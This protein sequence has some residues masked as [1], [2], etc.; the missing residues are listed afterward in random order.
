MS[1]P[2][3]YSEQSE[4]DKVRTKEKETAKREDGEAR[5]SSEVGWGSTWGVEN[6]AGRADKQ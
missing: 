3:C 6:P 5:G 4:A 2:F 1:F